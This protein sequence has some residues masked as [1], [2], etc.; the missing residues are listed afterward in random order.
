[1]GENFRPDMND[2]REA[3]RRIAP[4]IHRTP[5]MTSA[6]LDEIAGARLFFKCE[7]LQRTGSFKMRGATNAIFSLADEEAAKGVV[8][9]SSGNHGAALAK[10]ARKRNIPAWVIM[11]NNSPMVKRRAVEAYGGQITLCEPTIRSRQE[12][13]AAVQARTG[14]ILIHPY[15][16]DRI[17]SGQGTAA[18]ELLE[19]MPDL[20]VIIAP[21]SGGGLLSGTAIASKAMKPGIRVIGAE[22]K[23]AD[24][25]YRS[26][27]SGHIES[28]ETADT[29]ADGLRAVLAPRTF[30]I[31][32]RLA[33]EI[34]TVTEEEI[35]A[36]MRLLW[37]RMKLV[38]EPSGAIS[39]APVLNRRI[40]SEG[41]RIGII[42]SGGNVDLASLPFK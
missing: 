37:E 41:K 36:A 12:T 28:N 25:A 38:V 20:D 32:Q 4:H 8:T 13:A 6:S 23:N 40:G 29:I 11:P 3:Q 33:D 26:L 35:V 39:A 24:D 22:P 9:P 16:N 2:I 30:A 5:I 14:A 7:N 21:V 34:S 15:D 31:L 42:L 10:A 17:V 1:M 19:D 27:K 18:A